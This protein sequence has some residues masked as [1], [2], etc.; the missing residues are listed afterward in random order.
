MRMFHNLILKLTLSIFVV[1]AMCSALGYFVYQKQTE[2]QIREFAGEQILGF[3]QLLAGG[4]E[5]S[6]RNGKELNAKAEVLRM[7]LSKGV[8][9]SYLL[10]ERLDVLY[11]SNLEVEGRMIAQMP[12]S[13]LQELLYSARNQIRPL[14]IS[15]ADRQSLWIA[16]A[17]WLQPK[18][19]ELIST[20]RG[21]FLV[22]YDYSRWL[23]VSQS[24]SNRNA[25]IMSALVVV[26]SLCLLGLLWFLVTR[27]IQLLTVAADE[28]S[29]DNLAAPV[30]IQGNDEITQLARAFNTLMERLKQTIYR[31]SS[32]EAQL[33]ST[34]D[35]AVDRIILINSNGR[36]VEANT[37]AEKMF[38]MSH[39]KLLNRDISK[40]ICVDDKTS[41]IDLLQNTVREKNLGF[42][43]V[44]KVSL[45]DE[46]ASGAKVP[47]EITIGRHTEGGEGFVLIVRDITER[48]EMEEQ[49]RHMQRMDAVGKLTTGVAHDFNNLL[50]VALGNLELLEETLL[51][52]HQKK[53]VT[54]GIKACL[55]GANL[56]K[57]LL[58]FGRQAQLSPVVLNANDIISN[59][60]GLF[61]RAIPESIEIKTILNADL[62]R[63]KLDPS[64]LES[65]ILNLVINARDA[66]SKNGVI[67]IE[68][69]NIRVDDE[70]AISQ[71]LQLSP[72]GYV[73]INI[74]DTGHGIDPVDIDK[75]FEPF[76]TTKPVG[77]G[78]GMGLAMVLGFA[79]QSK[80]NVTVS[81]EPNCGTT[82]KLYFPQTEESPDINQAESL[83]VTGSK[84][85]ERILL[86]EDDDD[87]RDTI[88]RQLTSLNY[89][90]V[91]A[92]DG[93]TAFKLVKNGLEFN[94]LLTD[95]VMPGEIQGP[96]LIRLVRE[97]SPDKPI[98]MMSGYPKG[99]ND[100]DNDNDNDNGDGTL[101][102]IHK[103]T[104]PIKKQ[105]LAQAL[106]IS[107]GYKTI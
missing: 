88:E 27:R 91:T 50:A 93:D 18:A 100:N 49:L 25:L 7:T 96:E 9:S 34:M 54:G 38:E 101:A 12:Y 59:M 16:V 21:L 65:A 8:I 92:T 70:Y 76:F 74:S 5:G 3:T 83:L 42:L 71:G 13:H 105:E 90:V 61:E 87:V 51:S 32:S 63:S 66:I 24:Y 30:A 56:T 104:K 82:V 84:A 94:L 47:L 97:Q 67:T 1:G 39:A 2:S 15:D 72:G 103:L 10:D 86:V 20:E 80:G 68:T 36:I 98:I 43:G 78:T 55:R 75:V 35:S 4:I 23:R 64:Q 14:S 77:K 106:R 46:K 53:L 52:E 31:L 17:I 95:V 6:L 22:E 26:L 28:M 45:C 19:G 60:Y 58:V 44:G 99:V 81:S 85:S 62:W 33:R 102:R 57:Q 73:M 11:S 89:A 48:Y 107:L 37:S 29:V 40:L 41:F 69:C 79:L